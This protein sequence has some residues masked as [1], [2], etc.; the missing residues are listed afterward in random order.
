MRS[1]FPLLLA[2]TFVGG[3]G[4][5]A[6]VVFSDAG[7]GAAD[8]QDTVDGFRAEFSALNPFTPT[9]EDPDGRREINWDGVPD[10]LADP[11][12]LPG[13]FFNANIPGRARGIEFVPTGETEGFEV[14]SSTAS[15]VPILFDAP[16]ANSFF[17][18]ERIFRPI[19]GS[20][21]DILFFNPLDQTTP[22]LTRGF[23]AVFTGLEQVGQAVLSYFDIDGNLIAQESAPSSGS[24]NLSFLGVVF[25]DPLIAKVSVGTDLVGFDEAPVFDDFLYG[26][27]IAVEDVAP[28]PLP[29]GLVFGLTSIAGLL[30]LRRRKVDSVAV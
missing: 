15:G 27:P 11:N 30:V 29:A 18:P 25:D 13:D 24:A 28:I 3:P 1:F 14:S 17:S 12:E 26:E 4:F 10:A 23:G 19:N 22:A 16:D 2:V 20:S 9:N 6:P 8:I 5:A 7:P 21:F